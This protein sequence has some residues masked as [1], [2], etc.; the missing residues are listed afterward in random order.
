MYTYIMGIDNI[1][2]SLSSIGT[3]INKLSCPLGIESNQVSATTPDTKTDTSIP[4]D[5]D[6]REIKV[7]DRI[8]YAVTEG[9][10]ASLRVAVVKAVGVDKYGYGVIKI[11]VQTQK[12]V[13]DEKTKKGEYVP[14]VR[15]TSV[16]PGGRMIIVSR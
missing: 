3:Q 6:N 1:G 10:S 14:S 8:A 11:D 5:V 2:Q 4:V 15:K 16:N 7:G 13:Y 12:F 9:R